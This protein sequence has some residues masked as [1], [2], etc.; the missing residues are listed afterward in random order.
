M[1][2]TIYGSELKTDIDLVCVYCGTNHNVRDINGNLMT[3]EGIDFV[4]EKNDN[5]E[6]CICVEC[7]KECN[8]K[9]LK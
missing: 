1:I 9:D 3:T 6:Y 4:F 8:E 7:Q 5:E 2:K